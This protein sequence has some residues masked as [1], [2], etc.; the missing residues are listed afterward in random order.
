MLRAGTP[1][2]WGKGSAY[3]GYF[4]ISGDGEERPRRGRGAAA[5]RRR[6]REFF[7]SEWTK[8]SDKEYRERSPERGEAGIDNI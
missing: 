6:S 5:G 3:F 2:S 4:Q 1:G 8:Y 7:E